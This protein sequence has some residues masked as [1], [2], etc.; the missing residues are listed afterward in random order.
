[1]SLVSRL[2]HMQAVGKSR[3][4]VV[5]NHAYMP[6]AYVAAKAQLRY[7]FGAVP[8]WDEVALFVQVCRAMPKGWS[9]KRREEMWGRFCTAGADCDN[10][11]GWVM[12]SLW[13]QDSVVVMAQ[14]VKFWG[15]EHTVRIEMVN[16]TGDHFCY[17]DLAEKNARKWAGRFAE[18][19][20]GEQ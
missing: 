4:R 13:E 14:C 2:V 9:K 18:L 19:E 20:A 1:M 11:A 5:K 10:I 12:D 15:D 16:A 17:K 3:P 7:E 8:E 6:N